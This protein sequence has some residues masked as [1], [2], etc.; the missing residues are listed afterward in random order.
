MRNFLVFSAAI[1]LICPLAL[2][3][4]VIP[5]NAKVIRLIVKHDDPFIVEDSKV[6]GESYELG[7]GE[8]AQYFDYIRGSVGVAHHPRLEYILPDGNW[9]ELYEG[10]IVV[11]P[12]TLR[13]FVHSSVELQPGWAMV[14]IGAL[15]KIGV[16]SD[17]ENTTHAVVIPEDATG[18][19]E[20]IMESSIDMVTWTRANPG[21]YGASTE[22]RFFRLRA[23]QQ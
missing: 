22:K 7:D 20:I 19:V 13:V 1:A 10:E 17:P 6:Y 9:A 5:D 12:A 11:G 8:I 2:G 21:T 23:L 18:P 14:T 15:S 3:Q 16:V 4:M